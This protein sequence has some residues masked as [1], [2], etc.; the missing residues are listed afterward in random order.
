MWK[1]RRVSVK[2]SSKCLSNNQRVC[3]EISI[4]EFGIF[5][6]VIMLRNMKF[7]DGGCINCSQNNPDI[8]IWQSS[9]TIARVG[10]HRGCALQ[11]VL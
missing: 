6:R 3:N 4:V 9:A 11:G 7:Y 1:F 8:D 5:L 10:R 2:N